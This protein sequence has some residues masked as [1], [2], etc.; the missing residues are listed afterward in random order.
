MLAFLLAYALIV[1]APPPGRFETLLSP[2]Y[3]SLAAWWSRDRS[4][5]PPLC[6][7]DYAVQRHE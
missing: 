5:M 3:S 1:T 2:F 6:L 4:R 7:A